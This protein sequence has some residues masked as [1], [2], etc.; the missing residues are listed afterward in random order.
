MHTG[1]MLLT[2]LMLLMLAC[3]PS[4]APAQTRA[5]L[6]A[7]S[8]FTSQPDLGNASSGNL[9]LLG[10]ALVG[11]DPRLAVLSFEDGT[12]GTAQA[13][14]AAIDAAF[15]D[16]AESD[17]SIL[18]LCTH[19]V[20]SSADDG[21]VYLLLGDG[22][23]ETPLH[24]RQLFSLVSHVQGEKLLII[25]ACYS[26]ALIGREAPVSTIRL[27]GAIDAGAALP[28]SL[29][30]S[31]HVLTSASG[32][33][34]SWYFDSDGLSTGAISYFASAL[35]S[36]LGLY[37]APEADADGD[38]RVTLAEMQRYLGVAVP[39]ST[40]QLLSSCP[41]RIELP[42]TGGAMLSRP[43][44]G[45]SY[46]S[47]LL[48]TD[49]PTLEF[50]FTA[51]QETSVQYRLVEYDA[52]RWNWD[53]AQTFLDEGDDGSGLLTPGRKQRALTLSSAAEGD[54]GY[55]M[56]QVFSVQD[57]SLILCSE[58]LIGVQPAASGEALTISAPAAFRP[59]DLEL[60][61][62]VTLAVPA[63]LT[64]SVFD[65]DGAL[66]RRLAASQLT[67]PGD[68]TARLY[69]D[70]RAADGSTVPAGA[71]TIAAEAIVGGQRRKAACNVTVTD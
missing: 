49:D 45:F 26:G 68:G 60:A 18:Y 33:E 38:G 3:A 14:G 65:T 2:A 15:A 53:E 27:P 19:G 51:A 58:R 59:G 21:Q 34:S 50:S 10:S 52:G 47:S 69:W 4:A 42:V 31:I 35:A 70:G 56:L 13:L 9:H 44:T 6:V 66:V 16:A 71:Y 8:E 54:S 36:G 7:C 24:A 37:G 39:S 41:E 61:V 46:G 55:L 28:T 43:L 25:D 5:L 22:S 11:A 62:S 17:L 20:L 57:G 67:H 40:A 12:I 1:K 48:T 23:R 29:D 32:A 30:P 64:V 63:E